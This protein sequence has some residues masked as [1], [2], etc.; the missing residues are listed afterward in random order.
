MSGGPREIEAAPPVLLG[1]AIDR[2]E[3]RESLGSCARERRAVH[4]SA[5]RRLHELRRARR[6]LPSRSPVRSAVCRSTTS[7]HARTKAA[8][9]RLPVDG[10]REL[11]RSSC[12]AVTLARAWK[13]MP[14]CIGVS[15]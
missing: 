6:A 15:G 2:G 10:P 13:R 4:G 1:E 7:C 8:T 5:A 9:S 11:R 3:R 14:F 12:P